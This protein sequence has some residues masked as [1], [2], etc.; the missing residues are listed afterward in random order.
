MRK[1]GDYVAEVYEL[2]KEIKELEDA[3]KD[4]RDTSCRHNSVGWETDIA[5]DERKSV[6]LLYGAL[7]DTR[8]KV[9]SI[10]DIRVE[11]T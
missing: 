7:V 10:M 11:E 8:N 9:T 1:I 2:Q 3:L 6:K 4:L 5:K